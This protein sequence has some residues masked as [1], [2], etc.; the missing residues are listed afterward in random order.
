MLSNLH[1]ASLGFSPRKQTFLKTNLGIN[2]YDFQQENISRVNF[3]HHY[4]HCLW[5]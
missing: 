1:T 5:R 4:A 2:N 3:I